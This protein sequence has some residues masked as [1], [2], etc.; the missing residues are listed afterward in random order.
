ML[1]IASDTFGAESIFS[2]YM[3]KL[4]HKFPDGSLFDERLQKSELEY[5]FRSEAASKSLAE[6]YVG[7][8]FE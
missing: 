5:L 2:W 1:R 3:T 4:L 6:N 8:S 7:F